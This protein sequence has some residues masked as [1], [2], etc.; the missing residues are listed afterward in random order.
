MIPKK[1]IYNS[2]KKEQKNTE[3]KEN[4]V[5]KKQWIQ[6][7]NMKI[8]AREIKDLQ[9]K[10]LQFKWD[11]KKKLSMII[12]CKLKLLNISITILRN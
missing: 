6:L 12:N 3:D 5:L 11:K 2:K 7:E 8:N 4:K 10:M 9:R 1:V